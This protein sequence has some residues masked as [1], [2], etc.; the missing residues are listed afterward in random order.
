LAG[1]EAEFA[2]LMTAEARRLGMPRSTFTNSTGLPDSEHKMTARE[3]AFLSRHLIREYPDFYLWFAAKELRHGK[4]RF[5]NRNPLLF[6]QGSGVDGLK[7]GQTSEAGHGIVV[8]AVRDGQRMIAVVSGLE[9]KEARKNEAMKLLDWGY[10][11]FQAVKLYDATDIVGEAR[12][13]GGKRFFV[14]LQ[15]AGDVTVL[16]PRFLPRNKFEAQVVYKGPLKPPIKRGDQVAVLRVTT[17]AGTVSEAPLYASEDVER[18]NVLARGLDALVHLAF[19][20]VPL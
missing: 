4:H 6:V 13:W 19:R 11:S 1:S 17:P 20:W 5:T 3:L 15:G 9:T 12:V 18:T 16:L 10:K 7:T 2:K 14:P 8:S